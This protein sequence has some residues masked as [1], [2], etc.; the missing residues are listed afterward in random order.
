MKTNAASPPERRASLDLERSN[1][2]EIVVSREN[3]SLFDSHAPMARAS[4]GFLLPRAF[5]VD[6]PLLVV[7]WRDRA[8][9]SRVM[10][11]RDEA[12]ADM[13]RANIRTLT[14]V[15]STLSTNNIPTVGA[16]MCFHAER[17]KRGRRR[18]KPVKARAI[19]TFT[20]G[21]V[22][23]IDRARWRRR[24]APRRLA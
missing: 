19:E 8:R 11:A 20:T 13:V 10:R 18:W 1:E 9:A 22:L 3:I 24:W 15:T 2:D 21:T 5:D 17:Q 4:V 14:R 23:T 7:V 12:T 6:P 16:M